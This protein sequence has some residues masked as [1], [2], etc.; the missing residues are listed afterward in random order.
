MGDSITEGVVFEY[1]KQ[2]GDYVNQDELLVIVETDKIKVDV[3][4][5][6]SGILKK[7]YANLGDTIQVDKPLYEIDTAAPKPAG[8]AAPAAA[9]P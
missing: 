3:R 6:E 2:I 1:K 7:L 9:A 4:A 8:G 5:S